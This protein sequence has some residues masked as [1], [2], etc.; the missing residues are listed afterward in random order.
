VA[1]GLAALGTA[2]WGVRQLVWHPDQATYH[3]TPSAADG[4]TW[5]VGL[6]IEKSKSVAAESSGTLGADPEERRVTYAQ[7]KA[8]GVDAIAYDLPYKSSH[9]LG[10]PVPGL[11]F[12][13]PL[14]FWSFPT[15]FILPVNRSKQSVIIVRA[16][17]RADRIEVDT[18]PLLV[19]Q[20]RS[21]D[22]ILVRNEGWGPALDPVFRFTLLSG[23]STP[24]RPA[25]GTYEHTVKRPALTE[26]DEIGLE[27][28]IEAN[29]TLARETSLRA[30]GEVSYRTDDGPATL[31]F[32]TRV[33]R[34][35]LVGRP[36]PVTAR[37]NVLLDSR[38][39]GRSYPT[40]LLQELVPGEP[41]ERFEVQVGS[42]RT[43]RFGLSIELF[44]GA[45]RS[46]GVQSLVLDLFVP[47][48]AAGKPPFRNESTPA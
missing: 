26:K 1:G 48:S 32:E 25:P 47:R 40:T 20:D 11:D 13:Y 16:E 34:S 10:G 17:I 4:F 8:N 36:I 42:D 28:V 43:A 7:G 29:P 12:M 45:D 31:A 33:D 41:A 9:D 23:S 3:T 37:W 2:A 14:F 39:P 6:D 19:F 35:P 15:L 22:K 27:E 5:S 38:A 24:D 18:R 30:V 46:L 44:S 21:L